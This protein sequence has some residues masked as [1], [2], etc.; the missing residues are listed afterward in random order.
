MVIS[1]PDVKVS[2]LKVNSFEAVE[3]LVRWLD[4]HISLGIKHDSWAVVVNGYYKWRSVDSSWIVEWRPYLKEATIYGL[5]KDTLIELCLSV[6]LG[7]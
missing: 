2:K 3:D 7:E 5:E 6:D 4:E 1:L